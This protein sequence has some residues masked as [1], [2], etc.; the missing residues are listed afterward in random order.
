MVCQPIER[1]NV[2]MVHD[3][4][5][6]QRP[7]CL[8]RPHHITSHRI[9]I[10]QP[11]GSGKREAGCLGELSYL[12]SRCRK[13]TALNASSSKHVDCEGRK[14]GTEER[15][16]GL[17]EVVGLGQA[18]GG[19]YNRKGRFGDVVCEKFRKDP[20]APALCCGFSVLLAGP[21]AVA[22]CCCVG[23]LGYSER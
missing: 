20:G 2:S 11:G 9:T 19:G 14:T 15:R 3:R 4:F 5:D 6:P 1:G 18:G 7:C 8:R 10:G 22:V 16:T 23:R 21:V 13:G 12:A 17:V